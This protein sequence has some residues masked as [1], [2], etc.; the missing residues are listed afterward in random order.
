MGVLLFG[1][2][3]VGSPIFVNP[4]NFEVHAGFRKSFCLGVRALTW[5]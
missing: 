5:D 1:G 3:T 4:R 2:S